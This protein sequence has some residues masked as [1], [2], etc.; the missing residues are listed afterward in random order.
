[1]G[2][3]TQTSGALCKPLVYPCSPQSIVDQWINTR[4][5]PGWVTLKVY[6][7]SHYLCCMPSK[8]TSFIPPHHGPCCSPASFKLIRFIWIHWVSRHPHQANGR[9]NPQ[10]D[11]TQAITAS[12]VADKTSLNMSLDDILTS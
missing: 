5:L 10:L 4:F 11:T 2:A 8:F 6:Q 12:L 1:M 7:G 9:C 3:T